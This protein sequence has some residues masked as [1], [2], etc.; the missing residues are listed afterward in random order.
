MAMVSGDNVDP[1]PRTPAVTNRGSGL[2]DGGKKPR[3]VFVGSLVKLQPVG[4]Q[5]VLVPYWPSRAFFICLTAHLPSL[6]EKQA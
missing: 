6:P 1:E 4:R 2:K 5:G 3:A